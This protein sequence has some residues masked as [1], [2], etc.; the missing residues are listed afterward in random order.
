MFK[1]VIIDQNYI[2]VNFFFGE[3]PC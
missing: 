3:V 2:P 1:I